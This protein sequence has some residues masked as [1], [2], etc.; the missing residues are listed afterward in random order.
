M[1]AR[2]APGRYG[3]F[4]HAQMGRRDFFRHQIEAGVGRKT[5]PTV[6]MGAIHRQIGAGAGV[7]RLGRIVPACQPWPT[8]SGQAG[9]PARCGPCHQLVRPS[10]MQAAVE[11]AR[12]G[13]D[14]RDRLAVLVAGL[15]LVLVGHGIIDGL[16]AARLV[17]ELHRH[18]HAG[19]LQHGAAVLFNIAQRHPAGRAV[20]QQACLDGTHIFR[21]LPQISREGKAFDQHRAH[22]KG[23]RA[24]RTILRLRPRRQPGKAEF[25]RTIRKQRRV[26]RV[27]L[28]PRRRVAGGIEQAIISQPRRIGGQQQLALHHGR[29]RRPQQQQRRPDPSHLARASSAAGSTMAGRVL[30]TR[31]C[32]IGAG[33][34]WVAGV[35]CRPRL[36]LIPGASL[37]MPPSAIF[38]PPPPGTA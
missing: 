31:F 8:I 30:T 10:A 1:S 25:F 7:E 13:P 28:H 3:T 27:G 11:I 18:F 23:Q 26:E 4:Q 38:S 24:Q 37:L 22:R 32:C 12:R 2:T 16:R 20:D 21:G 35:P 17:D 9:Q 19:A 36:R 15:A 29:R 5:A 33:L 34:A 14:R 6:A